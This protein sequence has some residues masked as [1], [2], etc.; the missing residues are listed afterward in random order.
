MWLWEHSKMIFLFRFVSISNM[1]IFAIIPVA[2]VE[3]KTNMI[4]AYL[5]IPNAQCHILKFYNVER[6]LYIS[7]TA[8]KRLCYVCAIANQHNEG[9]GLQIKDHHFQANIV[10]RAI[11]QSRWLTVSGDQAMTSWAFW[12]RVG[13]GSGLTKK[14]GSRFRIGGQ[15]W[16]QHCKNVYLDC[17]NFAPILVFIVHWGRV[18]K[19]C[20]LQIIQSG[21]LDLALIVDTMKSAHSVEK[22][23]DCLGDFFILLS[24]AIFAVITPVFFMH[25][26]IKHHFC[27]VQ[28]T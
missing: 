13:F 28:E 9:F 7:F 4:L 1:T 17:Y 12:L 19:N 8:V 10:S 6:H 24:I 5:T 26:F 18:S 27:T 3:W 2:Q 15:R 14:F 11:V 21:R 22:L 16:Q 20:W 25:G 23:Q